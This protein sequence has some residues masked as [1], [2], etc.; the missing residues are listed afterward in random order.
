MLAYN[1]VYYIL[2]S[3]VDL[4]ETTTIHTTLR[5]RRRHYDIFRT[6]IYGEKNENISEPLFQR[7]PNFYLSLLPP[8]SHLK[9]SYPLF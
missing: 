3:S 2:L 5:D 7:V 4:D 9:P 1:I 6:S 8:T